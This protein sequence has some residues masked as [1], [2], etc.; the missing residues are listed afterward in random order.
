MTH[1]L[2][3]EGCTA[4]PLMAYL[5]ALGV[6]RLVAE[7][8]DPDAAGC[9]RDGVFMLQS[10]LDRQSLTQFFVA[11]YRATPVLA[12]WNG[13]G[14]FITD[15]GASFEVIKKV[16]DHLSPCLAD[17]SA[18]VKRAEQVRV[19]GDFREA[20]E[21]KKALER[22]RTD[23]KRARRK[24]S[25]EDAKQLKRESDLVESLKN[26][27]LVGVRNGFSDQALR[28]LDAC[29]AILPKGFGPAPLLGTGGLDG[30]LEFSVNFLANLLTVIDSS[31]KE[32]R[33][34]ARG[35]LFAEGH[36]ELRTTA[37]GQFSPG[38]V[39]GPN[40]TQGFEGR[41][42]VNPLDFVLMIEG[43]LLISGA[44]CR[45]YGT[46][47][48][49]K[50]AFPF[51][52]HSSAVG[53]ASR[54]DSDVRSARGELWLPLW[55]RPASVAEVAHLFAEGRAQL[56]GRQ[57]TS[58]VEFA[59]AA[60]SLGVDRGI[61]GF[62][63]YGFLPRSGRAYLAT[64]LGRLHVRARADVDLVR[65]VDSWLDR[66]R[67]AASDEHAPPWV[68]AALGRIE[69]ALL[70][71][72]QYGGPT[73]FAEMLCALGCGERGLSTNERFRTEKNL[74]PLAGL[75]PD[76]V[77]AADDGS[78][79]FE[80]ALS[81]AGI[82]DREGRMG[83]LRSNLEP[84]GLGATQDRRVFAKWLD[85][86][87]AVVWNSTELAHNLAAVLERRL[88]DGNRKGCTALPLA[89][90][91]PASLD[92]VAAFLAHGTDDCRMSDLLWGLTLVDH[93]RPHPARRPWGC[94]DL[95]PLP[96]AFALLRILFLLH[97]LRVRAGEVSPRPE[98]ALLALLRSGRGAEACALAARRL[99]AAGLVPMTTRRGG[100]P[101]AARDWSLADLDWR[102]L[103]GAL[104]F[105][106]SRNDIDR[107]ADLV[108]RPVAGEHGAVA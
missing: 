101:A 72:C 45:R 83:P 29:V 80:L 23:L 89:F 26:R 90:R 21:R 47:R 61:D 88:I 2:A 64:P 31:D 106:L 42:A 70:D 107:L 51:T 44:P 92:A 84:V 99:R 46:Q 9:W 100:S 95:L 6:L 62:V 16:R 41:S 28:W 79:E 18:A 67:P 11:E 73:R 94:A 25:E 66:F 60:S 71:L 15:S 76:W 49:P 20:R 58:G 74:R 32:R 10:A 77:R 17:V 50:A 33:A 63:R 108:V 30:H 40:A 43:A 13:D 68:R 7:Q 85:R 5:K 98:R 34:W 59:R 36:V 22:K 14:G 103:A 102:R 39:G 65:E 56:G 97:P 104:L 81:L 53:Y 12:P 55:G 38:G 24:L 37:I 75:S 52:V 69:S 96:R 8:K 48:S 78:A 82:R 93:T 4:E 105:P 54:T 91:H 19:L 27:I 3:L 35:A 87:R 86:D 57:A 1:E